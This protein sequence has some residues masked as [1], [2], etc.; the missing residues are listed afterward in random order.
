MVPPNDKRRNTMVNINLITGISNN[1]G[2]SDSETSLTGTMSESL[3]EVSKSSKQTPKLKKSKYFISLFILYRKLLQTQVS[4]TKVKRF[5]FRKKRLK[6]DEQQ[7]FQ[8][9]NP[10]PT[11]NTMVFKSKL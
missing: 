3:S 2:N 8:K 7:V 11:S 4:M 5:S 6:N 10:M 1:Y 9:I